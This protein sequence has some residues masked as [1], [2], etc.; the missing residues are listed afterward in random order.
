MHKAAILLAKGVLSVIFDQN[1]TRKK[2][3]DGCFAK[4]DKKLKISQKK[5]LTKEGKC[6][7]ILELPQESGRHEK[8]F[9]KS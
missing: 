2:A 1:R 3:F 7:I 6:G 5:V 8:G 9:E 4:S